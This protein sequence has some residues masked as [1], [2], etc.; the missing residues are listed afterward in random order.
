MPNRYLDA[1]IECGGDPYTRAEAILD[2]QRSN[3]LNPASTA[4]S[5]ATNTP[6]ASATASNALP[7]SSIST[8]RL[9]QPEPQIRKGGASSPANNHRAEG[10]TALPKAR[11]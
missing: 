5:R 11:A 7:S 1:L 8:S 10:A 9:A 4:G 2:M 6:S 3:A